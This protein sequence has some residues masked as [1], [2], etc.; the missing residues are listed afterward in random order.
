VNGTD[1]G[2][3]PVVGFNIRGVEPSGSTTRVL[4]VM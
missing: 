2:S 3:C 1:S 4:R